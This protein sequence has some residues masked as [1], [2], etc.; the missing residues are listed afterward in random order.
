MVVKKKKYLDNMRLR[1]TI[2]INL[3]PNTQI[4]VK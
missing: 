4:E 1:G 3:R 2:A